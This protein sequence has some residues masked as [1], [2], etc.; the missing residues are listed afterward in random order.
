MN[1][2]KWVPVLGLI[3]V[4]SATSALLAVLTY[5]ASVPVIGSLTDEL[6]VTAGVGA[7]YLLYRWGQERE[8]PRQDGGTEEER[9]K[10]RRQKARAQESDG[11]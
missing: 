2:D 10:K 9:R 5:Y 8:Q 11:F 6:A 7:L 3:W 4:T 1:D